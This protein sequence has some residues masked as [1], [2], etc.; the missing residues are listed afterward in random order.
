MGIFAR[1][2]GGSEK[3]AAEV[4][5]EIRELVTRDVVEPRRQHPKG[6]DAVA[7]NLGHLLHSVS[8][9]SVHQIDALIKDL[10]I[11]REHLLLDSEHMAREIAGY[12]TL[13]HAAMQSTKILSERL[14]HSKD[15]P[16]H[17]KEVPAEAPRAEASSAAE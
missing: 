17:S 15:A 16:P 13:G 8:A 7:E 6:G 11:L 1:K 5:G 4:E 12:A 14:T 9:H 10:K 3:P 2:A